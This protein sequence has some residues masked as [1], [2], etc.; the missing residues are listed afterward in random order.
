MDLLTYIADIPRRQSLAAALNTSPDYLWQMATGWRGKRPSPELAIQIE[1][2]TEGLVT[3]KELRPD[4]QGW[5]RD[6]ITNAVT[7]YVVPVAGADARREAA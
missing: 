3:M 6:P 2:V 5:L 1:Q 7:G 4:I